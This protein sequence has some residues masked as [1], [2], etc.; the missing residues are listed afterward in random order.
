VIDE[1]APEDIQVVGTYRL[2]RESGTRRGRLLLGG[3]VRP[4]PLISSA[5]P[6]REL[7]ELGRSCVLPAYRTSATIQLL[8]R[9]IA[10]YIGQHSIGALF[11]C[12]SFPASTP[13][14]MPRRCRAWPTTTS[15]RPNAAR[16]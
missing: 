5:R 15:P 14:P 8:W 11:G 13:M 3:R 9:G 4:R 7:L 16:W 1:G 10:D 6:G 12:A 2:L